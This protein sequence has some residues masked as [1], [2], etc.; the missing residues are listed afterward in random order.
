M[1]NLLRTV[2]ASNLDIKKKRPQVRLNHGVQYPKLSAREGG[3]ASSPQVCDQC[4]IECKSVYRLRRHIET[5]HK[6]YSERE[7]SCDYPGCKT[8]CVYES[9]LAHHK[10]VRHGDGFM[11]DHCGKRLASPGSRDNHIK[12]VHKKESVQM[13]CTECDEL[14]RDY[15]TRRWH[16]ALVHFPEKYKCEMCQ[17]PCLSSVTKGRMDLHIEGKLN[18]AIAYRGL[19]VFDCPEC[20]KTLVSEQALKYHMRIHTGVGLYKCSFCSWQ[21]NTRYLL[22]RHKRRSH[23]QLQLTAEENMQDDRM[24]ST[25]YRVRR[26]VTGD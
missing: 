9:A 11:C 13:K 26:Q 24:A 14:F 2:K 15:C 21:G 1:K 5:I 20:G 19:P 4:G 25:D 3:D 10:R 17:K 8:K 6:P 18:Q 16:L 12:M 23:K 22:K 7:F